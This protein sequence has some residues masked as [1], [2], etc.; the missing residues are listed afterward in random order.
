METEYLSAMEK[1][2]AEAYRLFEASKGLDLAA[3]NLTLQQLRVQEA[4]DSQ[5]LARDQKARA[6]LQ[7]EQYQGLISGGLNQYEQAMLEGYQ[8]VSQL[9]TAIGTLDASLTILQAVE[10]STTAGVGMG[11][12]FAAAAGVGI[13]AAGRAVVG[14]QLDQAEADLQANTLFASHERQVEQWQLQRD[15][16]QQD[17]VIGTAQ[18]KQTD[19]HH[20]AALQE[21]AIAKLQLEQDRATVEF[22]NRQVLNVEMYEWMSGVLEGAYASLLQQATATARLAQDQL[23]FERQVAPV[24]VIRADYWRPPAEWAAEGAKSTTDRRGLTGAERLIDDLTQLDQYA[25]Q[26]D[27]RKL[28]LTQTLSLAQRAPLQ[29]QIF[30]DTGV[31]Q[32]ATP[33]NW[34]DADFPGHYVRL[35]RRVRT[36][37][38]GLIPP[39]QGIRATLI[40]SGISRV[41]IG[42]DTFDE[43]VMRRDPE[44]V[45][46]TSPVGATGVFELDTQPDMLLPFEQM[47][48][49]T[50]WEFRLPKPANAFNFASIVDVQLAIDYTALDS[51]DYRQ[52]VI[53][54][55]NAD[56]RRSGER[57]FSLRRDFPDQWYALN[58]PEPSATTRD[59]TLSL[60]RSDFPTNLDDVSVDQVVLY[61]APAKEAIPPTLVTLSHGG[62]GGEGGRSDK[63]VISTRRGNAADWESIQN[64][65]PIGD[66]SLTF[67]TEAGSLFDEDQVADILLIISYAGVAP[68]WPE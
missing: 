46:L 51:Y 60:D 18:I 31:L 30:R 20:A 9:R 10:L 35:I 38:V 16:A 23:A 27:Q 25:F 53:Q 37:V 67:K 47:G 24:T 61:L 32:V 36:T 8:S 43:V 54:Q 41:V 64:S 59:V 50:S 57:S 45:A 49:A 42:G 66:W 29:F 65:S 33:M 63:G 62:Q 52:Q 21:Q 34:F 19:D 3:A 17:Q 56:A 39:S 28:N 6:D 48:V 15:L 5:T 13:L 7:V 2:Q 44:A 26:T 68:G 12:A 40:A 14:S 1:G 4:A 11:A 55:L 22:L 58:N